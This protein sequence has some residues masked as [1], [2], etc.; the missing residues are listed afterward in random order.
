MNGDELEK[1]SNEIE[2][3]CNDNPYV[4]FYD[5]GRLCLDGNFTLEELRMIV[6]KWS[7]AI[8]SEVTK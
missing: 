2:S 6:S 5:D 4:W 8:D 3:N 1:L 7:E